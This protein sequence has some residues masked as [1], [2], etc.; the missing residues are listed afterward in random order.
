[1]W[2]E[3]RNEAEGRLAQLLPRLVGRFLDVREG[4]PV[5]GVGSVF[6][7]Q[8]ERWWFSSAPRDHWEGLSWL[9]A[10]RWRMRVLRRPWDSLPPYPWRWRSFLAARHYG[11]PDYYYHHRYLV[12][13]FFRAE[14][15]PLVLLDQA[16]ASGAVV[17]MTAYFREELPGDIAGRL[18]VTLQPPEQVLR[19]SAGYRESRACLPW[20]R[21]SIPPSSRRSAPAP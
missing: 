10:L 2:W 15:A 6:P 4:D 12:D 17:P 7:W 11:Y 18:A 5:C 20:P 14:L 21:S 1:M 3:P 9:G 16:A 19:F 13:Q 8:F